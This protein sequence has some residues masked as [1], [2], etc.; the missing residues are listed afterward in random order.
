MKLF[1]GLDRTDYQDLLRAI[2]ELL[3]KEGLRD[4]RL[5]EHENG[6]IVQGRSIAGEGEYRTHLLTDEDLRA[7]LGK[8]Y[9]RRGLPR[10]RWPGEALEA[11]GDQE[12]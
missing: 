5:W 10:R 7:L 2:G 9:G 11:A 3:D 8:A 6:L 1:A 12:A 4:V